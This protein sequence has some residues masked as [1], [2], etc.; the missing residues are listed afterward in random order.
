MGVVGFLGE[1]RGYLH[2]QGERD[3]SREPNAAPRR[4][5][6]AGVTLSSIY[7]SHYLVPGRW[8]PLD[9]GAAEVSLGMRE[10]R[11]RTSWNVGLS[12]GLDTNDHVFARGTFTQ[13]LTT[14]PRIA[15]RGRL[16]LFAGAVL[17]RHNG[18]WSSQEAPRERHFFVAGGDPYAALS[19]PW[20]RSAGAPLELHGWVPGDGDLVGYHP[21]LALG[22]LTSLTG[23]LDTPAAGIRLKSVRILAR[24]GVFAGAAM[25]AAPTQT[26]GPG[27]LTAQASAGLDSWRHVYA[28]AGVGGEIVVAGS[29]LRLRLDLPLFV[30]DPNLAATGRSG[31]F[32]FRYAISVTT[33]G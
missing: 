33:G 24:A 3:V 1:G 26:Y 2:L 5:V 27:I 25:G 32:A 12:W 23:R 18:T 20:T 13:D 6:R 19:N 10:T 16:H 11:T 4:Y 8:T 15:W 17:G 29:P 31:R 9:R 30:G 28:S 22:Q 7:D 21:G 14:A